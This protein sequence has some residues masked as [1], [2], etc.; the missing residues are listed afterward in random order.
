MPVSTS[1][2]L[3]ESINGVVAEAVAGTKLDTQGSAGPKPLRSPAAGASQSSTLLHHSTSPLFGHQQGHQPQQPQDQRDLLLNPQVLVE[4]IASRMPDELEEI[5]Q[6]VLDVIS[7]V[8][9]ALAKRLT[10]QVFPSPSMT[11]NNKFRRRSRYCGSYSR[12][13]HLPPSTALSLCA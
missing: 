7:N 10:V 1:S 4:R 5:D 11:H 6:E 8:S 12:D 13:S 2:S 3:D 9:G